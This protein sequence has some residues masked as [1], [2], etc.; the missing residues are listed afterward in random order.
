M[1]FPQATSAAETLEQASTEVKTS[2]S[3]DDAASKFTLIDGSPEVITGTT[4][5]K[6][7][8]KL[9]VRT[10]PGK[11]AVYGDTA[12]GVDTTLLIGKKSLPSGAVLSELKRQ[13]TDG[14]LL[15]PAIESVSDF[16]IDGSTITFT[17]ALK[18]G[19]GGEVSVEL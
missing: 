14:A 8:L 1:I 19:E 3:F 4:A 9:L 16:S 11:Y 17:V 6:E 2:F 7:W 13:I 18:S 5:V 10:I 15:C 12:F